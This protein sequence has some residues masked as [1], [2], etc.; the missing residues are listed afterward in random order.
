MRLTKEHCRIAQDDSQALEKIS[1]GLQAVGLRNPRLHGDWEYSA[2]EYR[3]KTDHSAFNR[4]QMAKIASI[5]GFIRVYISGDY[6]ALAFE[7]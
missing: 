1:E 2:G 3:V 6:L 5:P 7:G 4:D